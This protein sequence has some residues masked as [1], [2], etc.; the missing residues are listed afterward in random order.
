[1]EFVNTEVR[2]QISVHEVR[3]QMSVHE[4]RLQMSVHEVNTIQLFSGNT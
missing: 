2:L 3:L 4:V 1:M